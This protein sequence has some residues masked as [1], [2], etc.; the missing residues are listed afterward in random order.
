MINYFKDKNHKSKQENK[1]SKEISTIRKTVDTFV[2]TATILFSKTLSVTGRGWKVTKISAC[3]I[4][5][6]ITKINEISC[7]MI[8][9]LI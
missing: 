6:G 3:G 4:A 9:K 1:T 5:C 2:I 8:L 7:E